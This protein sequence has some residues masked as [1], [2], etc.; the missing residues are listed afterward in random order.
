MSKCPQPAVPDWMQY[1]WTAR[2][3][4]SVLIQCRAFHRLH[5][6]ERAQWLPLHLESGEETRN[7]PTLL[8]SPTSQCASFFRTSKNSPRQFHFGFLSEARGVT[9]GGVGSGALLGRFR[10]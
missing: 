1:S 7:L 6:T 10:R 3:R 5:S 8:L 4:G 2:K 9:D